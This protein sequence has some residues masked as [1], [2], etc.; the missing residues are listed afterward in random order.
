MTVY[1]SGDWRVKPG[2]EKEFVQAWQ[3]LAD[4]TTENV[5]SN[6]DAKLLNDGEDP[7][8]FV[9]FGSWPDEETIAQW[10]ASDGF[11]QHMTKLRDLTSNMRVKTF[12]VA[13]ESRAMSTQTR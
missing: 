7:S 11:R 6:A 12:Q 2:L 8:H 4:W 3:A 9:S 1:T 13:A 5:N 10:R